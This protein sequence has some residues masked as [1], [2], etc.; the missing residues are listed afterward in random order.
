[1]YKYIYL[2]MYV[3]T[4]V[5]SSVLLCIYVPKNV[6]ICVCK[7]VYTYVHMFVWYV[8]VN[9]HMMNN[10]VMSIFDNYAAGVRMHAFQ[11]L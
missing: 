2:R 8:C 9:V 4:Y 6:C 11:I 3:P 5:Y 1:M 7:Y 10:V